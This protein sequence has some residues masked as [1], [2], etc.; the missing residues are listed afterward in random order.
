MRKSPIVAI[1]LLG[2]AGLGV[3]LAQDTIIRGGVALVDLL[4]TV[5]DKKGALLKDL[6]Q[7]DFHVLE[8]G[9]E[10][11]IRG[12]TRDTNV[13]LTIG[14]L[15]DISGSVST[16]IPEERR[17]ARQFFLKVLRPQ[18]QAFVISFGRKA[19][20]L[21]DVTSSVDKLQKGL[22]DLAP[23]RI[24][25]QIPP[26]SDSDVVFAQFPRTRFP[27]PIPPR[28]GGRGGGRGGRGG[29]RGGGAQMGGTVLYDAVFL[30]SDEVLKPATGRKAIILI[31]DG[32]D[33]GSRITL[34]RALEATQQSDVIVYSIHVKRAMGIGGEPLKELSTETGGRVFDLNKNLDKI[35]AD[36]N[37]E[38]RSQYS[39]SYVSSNTAQDGGYRKIEVQMAN[40]SDK[41]QARKGYY[42]ARGE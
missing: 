31:T 4:V 13:P 40:K 27:L 28:G 22:D 30:A 12:F 1:L 10:Q 33:Q 25:Q 37:D 14:M 17:A 39:L 18:D 19:V 24:V 20:L 34:A 7:G 8:D 38:L 9:K 26:S 16:Q 21:Q 36:I 23:D 42:A 5:R 15:V 29:G 2:M 35:F 41:A 3:V 32:V 6:R 11:E